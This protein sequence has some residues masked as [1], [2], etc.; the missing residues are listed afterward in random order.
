MFVQDSRELASPAARHALPS[1]PGC[2]PDPS[3]SGVVVI[4][5]SLRDPKAHEK[6]RRW[7]RVSDRNVRRLNVA[8]ATVG[9][10]L[11]APIMILIA[12]AIRLSSPGPILYRQDRVGHD[13]RRLR[14]PG[15]ENRRRSSNV[16]GR[17]FTMYKFRTMRLVAG[18]ASSGAVWASPNDPR[19][20]PVGALLRRHRL[21][22]LPQL[23]NVLRGDM[24]VVGPR[25]EQP[26]IFQELRSRVEAYPERQAV[27][28]GITGW[29]Q[30]NCRYDQSLDDVRAK[31]AFDL[32]YIHRRSP[33]EDL[34]IMF[35]TVPVMF[36]ARG[37]L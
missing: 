14:G 11:T 34:K 29:A 4:P 3:S 7:G 1:R 32:E 22:E 33:G 23:F 17:I 5:A 13:R 18:D 15:S 25:P 27:L 37:S 31:V 30:I 10:L 2:P 21:D 35:R 36:G 28:P 12:C 16:G 19:I 26:E 20:T 24:N 9:I 6:Y 8:V